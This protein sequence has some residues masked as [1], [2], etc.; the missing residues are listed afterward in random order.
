MQDGAPGYWTQTTI[1]EFSRRG[2]TI[3]KWPPYS[4]D[5]N[6]IEAL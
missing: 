4:P 5:L 2:V 6:P 3:L 1:K